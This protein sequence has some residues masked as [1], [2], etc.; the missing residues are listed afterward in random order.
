MTLLRSFVYALVVLLCVPP[1]QSQSMQSQPNVKAIEPTFTTIDVPGEEVTVAH[2]INSSGDIVGSYGPDNGSGLDQHGF[3]YRDGSFTF[4]DY[5]DADSTFAYGIND[6]GVIVG[7]AEFNG[8]LTASGFLYDGAD[9]TPFQVPNKPFTIGY[10]INNAGQVVGSAGYPGA[11]FR[12]FV[13]RNGRFRFFNFP[14][15]DGI[16]NPSS[17]N[18]LDQIVGN[19]I[20]GIDR[21]AYQYKNGR[22]K[23]LSFPGALF[24]QA[25]GINDSGVVV[26]AYFIDPNI[27]GFAYKNGR[28]LSFNFPGAIVTAGLGINNSG[29]IVGQYELGD[30]T[31]HGFV[32]SPITDADFEEPGK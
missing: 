31:R 11:D 29:Q 28:Y 15:P 20:V 5:P 10:G 30:S 16:A 32:T 26:G 12:G 8:G 25:Y 14:G 3:L 7:S 19:N 6:S 22:F 24:T 1:M 18:N 21:Y 23:Q 4:I 13:R 9:F 27:Y 17:I 2:G